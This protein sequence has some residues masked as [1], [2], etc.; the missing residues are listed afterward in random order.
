MDKLIPSVTSIRKHQ[1]NNRAKGYWEL[2]LLI[3]LASLLTQPYLL[4]SYGIIIWALL[5]FISYNKAEYSIFYLV[6]SQILPDISG[7]PGNLAQWAI[8]IWFLYRVISRRKIHFEILKPIALFIMPLLIW[9]SISAI[10]NNELPFYFMELIKGAVFIYITYDAVQDRDV[11]FVEIG[12]YIILACLFAG[13][14]FWTG[15]RASLNESVGF[16]GSNR[17]FIRIEGLR[18]NANVVMVFLSFALVGII[19]RWIQSQFTGFKVFWG[20]F[21]SLLIS[22]ILCIPPLIS[23]QSRTV[24]FLLAIMLL[25]IIFLEIPHVKKIDKFVSVVVEIVIFLAVVIGA[26]NL[27]LPSWSLRI[28]SLV[29]YQSEE[30]DLFSGRSYVWLPGLQIVMNHP[31]FGTNFSEFTEMTGGFTTSHNTIIDSGIMAGIPGMVLTAIYFISPL[32][33]IRKNIKWRGFRLFLVLYITGL[34]ISMAIA[35]QGIKIMYILWALLYSMELYR[36]KGEKC[37]SRIIK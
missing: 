6:L 10:A 13:I 24:Y 33:I 15:E 25:I 27:F 14:T 32:F 9:L 5:G 2:L 23:T 11:D 18:G 8:I 22:T 35:F 12:A 7:I 34:I 4:G 3:I 17:G 30:S 31:V 29:R 28:Q 19:H 26:L 21:G 20:S 16:L 36:G 1:L 37:E